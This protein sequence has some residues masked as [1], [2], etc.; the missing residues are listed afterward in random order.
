MS[1]AIR[2]A[3]CPALSR[4]LTVLGVERTWFALS[5]MVAL[6][7]L[8]ALGTLLPPLAAFALL[9]LAGRWATRADPRLL[10]VLAAAWRCRPRYDPA[11]PGRGAP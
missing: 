11:K 3:A 10:A 6:V 8:Q 9:C 4:P 7:L 5:L 2:W 1:G